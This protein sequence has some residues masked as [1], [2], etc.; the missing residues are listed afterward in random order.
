[1][2]KPNSN[3]FKLIN[4]D[5]TYLLGF[6]RLH[7]FGVFTVVVG[8]FFLL[9]YDDGKFKSTASQSDVILAK[10]A[11][12]V[13]TLSVSSVKQNPPSH[14]LAASPFGRLECFNP[15]TDS[16]N[17]GRCAEPV[18]DVDSSK[19]ELRALESH[20]LAGRLEVVNEMTDILNSCVLAP[21]LD[22]KVILT[23]TCNSANLELTRKL[24]HS[25]LTAAIKNGGQSANDAYVV[26][27]KSNFDL[28]DTQLNL[29]TQMTEAERS[30][31]DR[32][33]TNTVFLRE[34]I[35]KLGFEI[36]EF[37]EKTDNYRLKEATF[38]AKLKTNLEKNNIQKP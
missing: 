17:N 9:S 12:A 15:T 18:N 38:L 32:K 4:L 26:W 8:V 34:E 19:M 35:N 30:A 28:V 23:E 5:N 37:L 2:K 31:I 3:K 14:G 13:D 16:Q 1:M 11:S 27:L 36:V 10:T 25:T 21:L 22:P 29:L 20:F 33:Y 7:I 6:D 24:I